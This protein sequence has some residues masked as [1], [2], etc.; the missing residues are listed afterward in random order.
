MK[1]N[2]AQPTCIL[3]KTWVFFEN[4][5]ESS[6]YPITKYLQI[7]LKIGKESSLVE[8][9]SLRCTFTKF[10]FFGKR[11]NPSIR[12]KN[13]YSSS[14]P[15]FLFSYIVVSI[16]NGQGVFTNYVYLQDEV[17]DRWSKNVHF[18]Q[19]LYHKKCQ[20]RGYIHSCNFMIPAPLFYEVNDP[21][22][23]VCYKP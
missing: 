19:H 7:N 10:P 6:E 23:Q 8:S 12:K 9:S 11:Q 16:T 14:C 22:L 13:H 5:I 18:F 20:H 15:T 1:L 3:E 4:I 21:L 2:L 17:I